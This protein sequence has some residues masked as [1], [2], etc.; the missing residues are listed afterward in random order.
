M[1]IEV[2][3]YTLPAEKCHG[4]RFTKRKMDEL[5]IPYV[6]VPLQSTPGAMDYV[7]TLGYAA[8]PVVEAHYGGGVT[9]SWSGYSPTKIEQLKATLG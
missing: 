2:K 6:E 3:L 8:A 7:K 9:T 4:C 1:T 5:G